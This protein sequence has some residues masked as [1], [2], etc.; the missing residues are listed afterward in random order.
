M[1]A[2]SLEH[3][4]QQSLVDMAALRAENASLQRQLDGFKRLLFGRTSERLLEI[5]PAIQQSLLNSREDLPVA[6]PPELDQEPPPD[7][8]PR[9]K[10]RQNAVNDT[11]LR[12]DDTVLVKVIEVAPDLPDGVSMDDG[13]VITTR[14]TFRL[15]QR[16]ASFWSTAAR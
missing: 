16:R 5:D 3:K 6:P 9:R 4:Y 1:T 13:E 15:A 10:A 2:L 14:S 8:T 7:K 12:F 11:G